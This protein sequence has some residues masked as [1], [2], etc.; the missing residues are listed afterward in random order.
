MNL[1]QEIVIKIL[2]EFHGG[3]SFR[4]GKLMTKIQHD[5]ARRNM[6][7]SIVPHPNR[8]LTNWG[9]IYI[10]LHISEMK[11]YKLQLYYL[12]VYLTGDKS[13]PHSSISLWTLN[14]DLSWYTPDYIIKLN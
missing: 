2:V 6:L 10:K 4:N 3:F 1:P 11:H 7:Q 8:Y 13:E 14:S 12:D 9:D 5:D